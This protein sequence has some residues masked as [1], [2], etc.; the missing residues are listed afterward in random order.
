MP[1]YL[2]PIPRRRFL[3]GSLAAAE[4]MEI[5]LPRRHVKAVI[6]FTQQLKLQALA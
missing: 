3:K 1:V 5:R 6:V 2:P 4:L